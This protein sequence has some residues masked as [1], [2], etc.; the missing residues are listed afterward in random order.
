MHAHSAQLESRYAWVRLAASVALSSIGGVGMW[1]V[2]VALPAMQAEFG[3][4][5]A[6][7]RCPTR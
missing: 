2:V 7:R 4:D 1:S 3:V 5:R 6:A